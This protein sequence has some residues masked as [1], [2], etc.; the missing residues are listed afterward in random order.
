MN[1]EIFLQVFFH[2]RLQAGLFKDVFVCMYTCMC[3]SS[4]VWIYYLYQSMPHVCKGPSAAWGGCWILELQEIMNSSGRAIIAFNH[5]VISQPEE[6]YSLDWLGSTMT[7]CCMCPNSLL[8]FI[9]WCLVLS[10]CSLG[11]DNKD[12]YFLFGFVWFYK[13]F[14]LVHLVSQLK[15]LTLCGVYLYLSFLIILFT[16]DI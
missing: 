1:F 2:G 8:T 7:S 6:S 14:S 9:T 10:Q 11:N 4:S 12:V 15:Y 5:W 3:V 16:C 13:C